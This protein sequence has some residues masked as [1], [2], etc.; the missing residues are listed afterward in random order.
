VE[1]QS[2]SNYWDRCD[3]GLATERRY[4]RPFPM[5]REW[6]P[7]PFRAY[8]DLLQGREKKKNAL[9]VDIGIKMNKF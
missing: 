8:Q 6:L 1:D 5:D 3:P 7:N 9:E 2:S 4:T